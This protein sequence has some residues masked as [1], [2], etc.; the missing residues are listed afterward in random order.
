MFMVLR[1]VVTS[2][3]KKSLFKTLTSSETGGEHAIFFDSRQ[4]RSKNN[5]EYPVNI[6][7]APLDPV[8]NPSCKINGRTI[9]IID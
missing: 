9:K 8:L 1:F 7:I 6:P 2:V 4:S 5:G 3:R